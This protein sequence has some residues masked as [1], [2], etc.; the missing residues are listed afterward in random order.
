ME[1][2]KHINNESDAASFYYA[3][4]VENGLVI[5]ADHGFYRS[6]GESAFDEVIA[7]DINLAEL[8]A[9]HER[10]KGILKDGKVD[11][12]EVINYCES[13]LVTNLVTGTQ[14]EPAHCPARLIPNIDTESSKTRKYRR[15]QHLWESFMKTLDAC[16]DGFVYDDATKAAAIPVTDNTYLQRYIDSVTSRLP[17]ESHVDAIES[18]DEDDVRAAIRKKAFGMGIK[19][20]EDIDPDSD[21]NDDDPFSSGMWA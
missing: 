18:H 20:A 2:L 6:N 8:Q 17:V 16:V 4:V 11:A 21:E 10:A 15:Y 7:D 13:L 9:C 19:V 1:G 3:V 5:D 12:Q 14:A